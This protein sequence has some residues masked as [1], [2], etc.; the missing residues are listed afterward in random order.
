LKSF[1]GTSKLLSRDEVVPAGRPELRHAPPTSSDFVWV[2]VHGAKLLRQEGQ[3]VQEAS[4]PLG[5]ELQ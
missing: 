3:R 4:D 5:R 1:L 2:R